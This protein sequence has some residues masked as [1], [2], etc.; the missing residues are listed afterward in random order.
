MD[1]I[2]QSNRISGQYTKL[3]HRPCRY[4][5]CALSIRGMILNIQG[6]NWPGVEW[7]QPV[8]QFNYSVLIFNHEQ[9]WSFARTERLIKWLR[10]CSL[11][12]LQEHYEHD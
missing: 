2:E 3:V 12:R 10:L 11:P 7:F 9:V 4:H 5:F 8:E 6:G 1:C